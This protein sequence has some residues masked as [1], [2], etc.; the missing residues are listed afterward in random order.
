MPTKGAWS[1]GKQIYIPTCY[2][3]SS[4][5]YLAFK[6]LLCPRSVPKHLFSI[7]LP[8]S[9]LPSSP[10]VHK[11]TWSHSLCTGL[12][13]QVGPLTFCPFWLSP[14]QLLT[15]MLSRKLF[16][17]NQGQLHLLNN[18]LELHFSSRFILV[19]N[20]TIIHKT[21]EFFVFFVELWVFRE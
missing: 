5:I 15:L 18:L 13:F 6:C 11:I 1:T 19:C 14:T 16:L 9:P 2:I 10:P 3:I 12:H 7:P 4:L 20:Y 17:T 8:G 21:A